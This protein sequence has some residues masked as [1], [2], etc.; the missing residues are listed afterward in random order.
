M[1]NASL[2]SKPKSTPAP[3]R[4]A[5]PKQS[6][7]RKLSG[8]PSNTSSFSAQF[9][10][11]CTR[12]LL[13]PGNVE[14]SE[15]DYRVISAELAKPTVT[16]GFEK[17]TEGTIKLAQV[18]LS[19]AIQIS[20]GGQSGAGE[21]DDF[22]AAYASI[23]RSVPEARRRQLLRYMRE[24]LEEATRT[25]LGAEPAPATGSGKVAPVSTSDFMASLERQETAQRARDA[26]E[27]LLVP[28]AQ[29]AARLNMTPQGLHHA[30]KAKRIFTLPGA[31]GEQAYPAFFADPK[32]D[33]KMLEKV[34]KA[35]GDLPGAAKWDFFMS[36]RLS[37]GKRTPLEALAKGKFEAVMVAA[38]AFAEE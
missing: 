23:V 26:N 38:N 14:R 13:E 3:K 28:A 34:S 25:E 27:G 1:S 2:S 18:V 29:L 30:L 8:A 15:S 10:E 5:A 35:L 19:H 7:V 37:L 17:L 24:G 22:Q 31:S 16:H 33:R 36:P 6:A 12:E 4:E 20:K 32:Q 11:V 9:W 21:V